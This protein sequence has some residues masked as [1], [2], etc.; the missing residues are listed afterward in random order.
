MTYL[1]A[2]KYIRSSPEDLNEAVAGARI[3]KLW[4]RLGNPERKLRFLRLAG[5]NGKTVCAEMLLSVFKCSEHTAGCFITPLRPEIRDNI[6]INGSPL[7]F[8]EF[9][10]Y[11]EQV[12]RT[13]TDINK[14][15]ASH[16]ASLKAL[17][18]TETESMPEPIPETVLTGH[19][20]L[21]TAALLAFCDKHCN[22]CFIESDHNHSDPTRFLPSPFAAA[23]CGTIPS[24]DKRE[25]HKIKAY[26]CH[27]IQE[28]ISAPQDIGA[29]NVI[30]ATCAMINARFT[31]PDKSKLTVGKTT[32]FGT[33][34]SYYQKPYRLSLCGKFQVTNAIVVIEIL[35]MLSERQGYALTDD[36]IRK[37]LLLTKI[38]ARFEILS[39][40]PTI[41]A[42]STHS[43]IAIGIVCDSMADFRPTIGSRVRLCLPQG[44]L[45]EQYIDA[46]AKRDYEIERIITL[47][48]DLNAPQN[49][50]PTVIA[51]K[52]LREAVKQCL[53]DLDGNKILL[54]SGHAKFTSEI[55]YEILKTLGF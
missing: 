31:P 27:G 39:V 3:K 45:V 40:S 32:L 20:I 50:E 51:C 12:Y 10:S 18:V 4:E 17:D 9:A 33:E 26:L 7:A 41:I 8:D 22:I 29:H 42:D 5:S 46:L 37:G 36:Q 28:I 35:K 48:D 14:E 16:N 34:F 49:S 1:N 13:V 25:I 24:G 6:I 47:S 19:E 52:K 43:E 2:T 15:I 11:V 38:P 44:P 23:I 55:R 54:I 21:L 30:L 53:L